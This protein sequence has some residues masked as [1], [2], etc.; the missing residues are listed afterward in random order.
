MFFR[1][2]GEKFQV[3]LN[4]DKNSGYFTWGPLYVYDKIS[5][6]SSQIEK[7]FR[8]IEKIKTRVLY[9]L[10]L[11]LEN[12]VVYDIMWKNTVQPDRPQRKL[13]TAHG[14]FNADN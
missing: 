12:R 14:H 3:S 2:C 11:F 8:N 10:F 5:L 13:K 1:K 6:N 4:S 7:C 9:S